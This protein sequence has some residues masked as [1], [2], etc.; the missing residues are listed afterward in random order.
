MLPNTSGKKSGKGRQDRGIF[1]AQG[2]LGPFSWRSKAI[3]YLAMK[4]LIAVLLIIHGL[5]VASQSSGSF[6]PGAGVA[7]PSWL[8]WFPVNLRSILG[9]GAVG[10]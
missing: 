9:V 2:R 5:I 3:A 6:N 7:N 8:N 1:A 4:I 10:N